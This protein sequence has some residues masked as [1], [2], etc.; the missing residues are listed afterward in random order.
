MKLGMEVGLVP[1]HIVL[2]GDP[3]PPKVAH[4]NFRPMSIVT[5]SKSQHQYRTRTPN[6]HAALLS[7]LSFLGMMSFKPGMSKMLLADFMKRHYKY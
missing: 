6:Q 5:K 2:D 1:G 7:Y 3:S 4:P